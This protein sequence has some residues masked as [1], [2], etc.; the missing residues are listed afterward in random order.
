MRS[1]GYIGIALVVS[2]LTLIVRASEP[3]KLV[4]LPAGAVERHVGIKPYGGL[5]DKSE[6]LSG[7]KIIGVRLYYANGQLF[8][9]TL[10][11]DSVESEL[12]RRW[13]RNGQL[14]E[15][16]QFSRGILTLQR[17]LS[18]TSYPFRGSSSI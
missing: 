11:A 15:T 14:W 18:S 3:P 1:S 17:N 4:P 7:E 10:L 13:H 16:R 6:L 5:S 9:E 2:A 8:E 12:Q